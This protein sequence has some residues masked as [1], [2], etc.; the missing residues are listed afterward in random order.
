MISILQSLSKTIH[1]SI[2]LAVLLFV[3]LFFGGGDFSFDRS[4]WSWLF[5][6]FHVLSG[7]MW[8]GLLWYLNFVQIPSM[9]NRHGGAYKSNSA[10]E[11]STTAISMQ[12]HRNP[13]HV[14]QGCGGRPANAMQMHSNWK[15]MLPVRQDVLPA[16]SR[17]GPVLRTPLLSAMQGGTHW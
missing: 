1:L 11:S 7:V 3:G 2:I 9:P 17:P 13:P 15:Q 16:W 8:I 12:M 6:Y 10:S 4:F 5:R 14:Q